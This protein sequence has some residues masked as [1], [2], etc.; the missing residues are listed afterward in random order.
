M[1]SSQLSE[2]KSAYT[3]PCYTTCDRQEISKSL[4]ENI[5]PI[6]R[7]L[8]NKEFLIGDHVTYVD[9]ILFEILDFGNWVTEGKLYEVHQTL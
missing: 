4:L 5:K 3:V 1:I 8:G 6:V 2:I 7:Y 9:F